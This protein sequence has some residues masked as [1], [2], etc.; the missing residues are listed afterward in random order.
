MFGYVRPSFPKLTKEQQE[1]FGAAYC[2]LCREL[3]RRYGTAAQFILNYDLTF[4]AI[5]LAD[6]AA[7][8]LSRGRCVLHPLRGRVYCP[9]SESLELAADCSVILTYWQLQDAVDDRSGG[10]KIPYQSA[11]AALRGAY[12]KARALRPA[13][14]ASTRELLGELRLLE[15]E[16]CPS[17]DRAADTF[18]RLLQGIACEIEDSVKKRV[19]EQFLYHLG[20]W[21]YL[22][23]A[24]DDLEKDLKSGNY[25]PLACRF[26]LKEGKLE[27]EAR[28]MLVLSLD[29]SIQMM[30]AAY[31]L[32]DFGEWSP[33]IQST[34]YEGLFC[35]GN[36]VL[37]GTFHASGRELRMAGRSKEQL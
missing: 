12:R 4:L 24:A 23:D 29:K 33:I 5:V 35:V 36:A 10:K 19:L 1:L 26:S 16:Q 32:W 20:R 37:E 21:I 25:N 18:A 17:M 22:V 8:E 28:E 2:G 34:V 30:S 31:E 15:Q 27:G 11:K 3:H 6:P 13:F 9:G 7:P 14:D